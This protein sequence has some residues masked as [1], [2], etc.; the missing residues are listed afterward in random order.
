VKPLSKADASAVYPPRYELTEETITIAK[1]VMRDLWNERRQEC[2]LPPT[3]DR[4][5]SCKFASL[6]A[7]ELFGGRLAG[8]EMHIFVVRNGEVLDLN[9]EQADVLLLAGQAHF[10][11]P[12]CVLHRDYRASLGT[13]MPRVRHWL[14]MAEERLPAT[15]RI[16]RD[17]IEEVEEL[18]SLHI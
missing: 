17:V 14:K 3:D 15:A 9:E 8:N 2:G 11:Y 13:C 7:R 5:S 4:S 1:D 18:V 6:I 16:Y 10:E 12:K